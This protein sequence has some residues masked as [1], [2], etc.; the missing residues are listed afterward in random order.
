MA[1]EQSWRGK[2]GGMSREEIEEF[3]AEGRIMRM[4]CLKDGG[5]PY[6]VPMWHEW[7]GQYF[8]VIPRQKSAWAEYLKSNKYCAVSV[9]EERS[10]FRKVLVEGEAEVV[11]EPNVGGKWVPIAERM[12]YRYLGEHG[13]EYLQSTLDRPRWLFRI[14]PQKM[15]TW[16]GVGWAKRYGGP[17]ADE[18]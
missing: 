1:Q 10:P 5:K 12:S 11:E 18:P 15:T 2:I 16:Q 4:A 8:W 17:E 13:P 3:L 6:I 9:D 14:K 7:D